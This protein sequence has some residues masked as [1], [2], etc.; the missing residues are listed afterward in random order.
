MK[1]KITEKLTSGRFLFTIAT[2]G[3][4]VYSVVDKLIPPDKIY[5]VIMLVLVFYFT[6]KDEPKNGGTNA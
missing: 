2:A 5:E 1:E 3:V 6:K 4:F